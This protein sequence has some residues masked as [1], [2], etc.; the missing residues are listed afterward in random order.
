MMHAVKGIVTGKVCL[1]NPSLEEDE[2]YTEMFRKGN[3][4]ELIFAF[5]KKLK[6]GERGFE[7]HSTEVKNAKKRKI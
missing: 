7:G 1:E 2:K 4:K 6:V 5:D 3:I